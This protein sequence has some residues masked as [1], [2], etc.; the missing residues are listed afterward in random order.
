MLRHNKAMNDLVTNP[1][2]S[3]VLRWV[4]ILEATSRVGLA[5]SWA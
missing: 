5:L 4:S 1:V 2:H 3:P